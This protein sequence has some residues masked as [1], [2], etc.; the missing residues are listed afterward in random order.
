MLSDS[1]PAFPPSAPNP[2]NTILQPRVFNL[3]FINQLSILNFATT[4]RKCNLDIHYLWKAKEFSMTKLKPAAEGY[5]HPRRTGFSST[6]KRA[7]FRSSRGQTEPLLP[8]PPAG[9][10]R[11]KM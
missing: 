7:L 5:A 8:D 11:A 2:Q 10:K 9:Q 4:L 3:N 1:S 6:R